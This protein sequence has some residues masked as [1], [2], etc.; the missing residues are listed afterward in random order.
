MALLELSPAGSLRGRSPVPKGLQTPN[1][2]VPRRCP[3]EGSEGAKD[4][5]ALPPGLVPARSRARAPVRPR[6]TGRRLTD[7]SHRP[8]PLVSRSIRIRLALSPNPATPSAS[9]SSPFVSSP[10]TRFAGNLTPLTETPAKCNSLHASPFTGALPIIPVE[11]SATPMA[12]LGTAFSAMGSMAPVD[13]AMVA[14]GGA[15]AARDTAAVRAAQRY[16]FGGAARQGREHRAP[17]L[18]RTPPPAASPPRRRH[19]QRMALH[20]RKRGKVASDAVA[21]PSAEQPQHKKVRAE[22]SAVTPSPALG[23]DGRDGA[24]A[25]GGGKESPPGRVS[26]LRDSST[27]PARTGRD[28]FSPNGITRIGPSAASGGSKRMSPR[29]QGAGARATIS[30]GRPRGGVSSRGIRH[31]MFVSPVASS[32]LTAPVR[33]TPASSRGRKGAERTIACNC[34]KSKCLKLY[35]ECFANQNYC[36][37]TCNCKDCSNNAAN[38]EARAA[39]IKATLDRNPQAFRAKINSDGKAHAVGC[40]CKKSACLK[41]YCECFQAGVVCSS[42]CKCAEC[43]NFPGSEDMIKRRAKLKLPPVQIPGSPGSAAHLPAA[44]GAQGK[45]ALALSGQ[46]G[47]LGES[48]VKPEFDVAGGMELVARPPKIMRVTQR[49]PDARRAS[50]GQ[51]M[52]LAGAHGSPAGSWSYLLPFNDDS[53]WLDLPDA[54]A[55]LEEEDFMDG[56]TPLAYTITAARGAPRGPAGLCTPTPPRRRRPVESVVKALAEMRRKEAGGALVK[57][58][59]IFGPVR[60]PVSKAMVFEIFAFLDNDDLYNA[61]L[62]CRFWENLALDD[63]LWETEEVEDKR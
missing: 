9:A 1:R 46:A 62:V 56:I 18:T 31:T 44:R 2:Y 11:M 33:V 51:G 29:V 47:V 49:T 4:P 59:P 50:P 45:G 10:F 58:Y 15:D 41:K 19:D 36:G 16:V 35:C 30:I 26:T 24:A 23:T 40:H 8:P 61:C 5:W 25:D 22:Q 60:A 13:G 54:D 53:S 6:G 3:S 27:P 21:A 7:A 43:K 38:E 39:A 57:R 48:P 17:R 32:R 42:R 28:A 63:H 12:H 14:D 52:P 20:N 34:K 37:E 55:A